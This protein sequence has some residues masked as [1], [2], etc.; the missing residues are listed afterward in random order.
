MGG[1]AWQEPKSRP[2]VVRPAVQYTPLAGDGGFQSRH[3]SPE[4]MRV[5]SN[6]S[7]WMIYPAG[8][9]VWACAQAWSGTLRMIDD[10]GV[11]LFTY[12]VPTNL[13]LGGGWVA[14][15]LGAREEPPF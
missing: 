4:N 3:L 12:V 8:G 6:E 15:A 14:S 5:E 2:R 7:D 11:L 1:L 10:E 13:G 9:W